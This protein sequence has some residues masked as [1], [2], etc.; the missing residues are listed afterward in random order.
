MSV[1][2]ALHSLGLVTCCLNWSKDYTTDK[3]FKKE[4]GIPPNE[5]IIELISVGHPKDDY[6]VA[7]SH[8]RPVDEI[9]R[10]I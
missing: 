8:R 7:V 9:M 5:T 2:Y 10:V 4:F 1:V 6:T 3:L